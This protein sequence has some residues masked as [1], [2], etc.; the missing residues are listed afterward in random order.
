MK[1]KKINFSVTIIACIVTA[2]LT[3]FLTLF[4]INQKLNKYSR[5]QQLDNYIQNNYYL[6]LDEK[7]EQALIDTMLK[8]YVAGLGDK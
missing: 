8:G 3:C 5:L 1:S 7:T 2:L 4:I 6:D